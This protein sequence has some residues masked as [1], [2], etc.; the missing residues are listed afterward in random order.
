[1]NFEAKLFTYVDVI[2]FSIGTCP[3]NNS[4]AE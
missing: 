2:K 1:M 4:M 3:N